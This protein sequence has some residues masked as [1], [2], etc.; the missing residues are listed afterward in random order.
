MSVK[1]NRIAHD[2]IDVP[3]EK[4]LFSRD[5]MLSTTTEPVHLMQGPFD[6]LVPHVLDGLAIVYCQAG[7]GRVKINLSE[8]VGSPGDIFVIAPS[9][10]AQVVEEIQEVYV[11]IIFFSPQCM[12]DMGLERTLHQLAQT[13]HLSPRCTLTGDEEREFTFLY[14]MLAR[15]L[16]QQSDAGDRLA[17]TYLSTMIQRLGQIYSVP[18]TEAEAGGLSHQEEL[19][20]RFLMLLYEHYRRERSVAFYA[21]ALHL[22]PKYFARVIKEVSAR[23][24][25]ELISEMVISA[26]CALLRGTSLT[27]SQIA[28]ELHFPNKSFFGTY[29]RRLVGLSPAQYRER[30]RSLVVSS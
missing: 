11:R 2:L 30:S 4:G 10:I 27:V 12:S 18:A 5:G 9:S 24:P 20:R 26:A 14:E 28:D 29:F 16:A 13:A 15:H 1:Y 8:Y 3:P 23:A 6:L 21:R 7:R 22:T 19:Y 25:L 17:R